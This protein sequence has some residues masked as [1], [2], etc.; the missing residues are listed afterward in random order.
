M[1]RVFIGL[2]RAEATRKADERWGRQKGLRRTLRLLRSRLNDAQ[3][4]ARD[5]AGRHAAAAQIAAA[6]RGMSGLVGFSAAVPAPYPG[7]QPPFRR[8]KHGRI[9]R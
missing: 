2:S 7:R 1:E 6:R 3:C 9:K 4:R 8:R 5:A